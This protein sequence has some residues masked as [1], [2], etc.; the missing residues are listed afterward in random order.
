MALQGDPE[1]TAE[2]SAAGAGDTGAPRSASPRP[3][4]ASQIEFERLKH[5]YDGTPLPLAGG[6]LFALLLGWVVLPYAGPAPALGWCGVKLACGLWR[7]LDCWLFSRAHDRSQRVAH[8]HARYVAGLLADG[9]AWG[10]MGVLFTPSGDALLDGVV[11]AGVVGVCS[12]GVFTLIAHFRSAVWFML[13]VIGPTAVY[14]ATRDAPGSLLVAGGLA[15]YFCVLCLETRRSQ[16]RLLELLRLRFENAAIADERQRALLLAEYSSAAKSRFLATVSHALRTPLNGILGMTQL[17]EQDP[18]APLAPRQAGRVRVVHSSARHLLS[19]IG[20][21]LDISR[22]E[23]DRLEMDPQPT[24]LPELLQDAASLLAHVAGDKGLALTVR[25]DPALPAWAMCDAER[26]RQVLYNLLDNALRFTARG[27]VRLEAARRGRQIRFVVSD[28]GSGVPPGQAERIFEAFE[29]AEQPPGGH[30]SGTGLGLTIAR[31]LA[32]AMAGDVIHLPGEGGSEGGPG[33]TFVFTMAYL[34]CTERP[35]L[36]REAPLPGPSARFGG[37]V[38]VAEDN[39]INAM[40][41]T[42]ML[43]RLG[44]RWTL[45]EDG[46]QAL[47][48]LAQ[49]PFDLVLMDCQMPVLD[50][51]ETTRRWRAHE[52]AQPVPRRRIPIVAVTANAVLG[53]RQRCLDAGMDDHLPKPF[54]LQ[55]LLALLQKHLPPAADNAALCAS[56]EATGHYTDPNP[57]PPPSAAS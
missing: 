40:V 56:T 36:E 31:R 33:A 54:T 45:A 55:A 38:L 24:H 34:P 44:V 53:D 32:R 8:W 11:V 6:L 25:I 42:A 18:Q 27:E 51:W 57:S 17:L 15:V 20:D 9:L 14:H 22:I 2:T 28:T 35:G 10:A 43:D 13:A 49:Q 52:A 29:R 46:Q 16:A 19:V 7:L 12:V 4:I 21:L 50:G 1:R 41:A 5:L 23:F 30:E 26:V 48:L 3:D 39:P 37:R 47:A